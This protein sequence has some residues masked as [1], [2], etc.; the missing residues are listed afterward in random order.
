M[1]GQKKCEGDPSRGVAAGETMSVSPVE[2]GPSWSGVAAWKMR[3]RQ[4]GLDSQLHPLPSCAVGFL[5][6]TFFICKVRCV[7]V[8]A[9]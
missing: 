5:C 6:L 7:L 3:A 1:G 8:I 2:W 9:A 4:P